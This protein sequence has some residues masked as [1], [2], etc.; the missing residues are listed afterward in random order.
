LD[1]L[2]TDPESASLY[3][4]GGGQGYFREL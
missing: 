1:L 3:S 2:S 4:E